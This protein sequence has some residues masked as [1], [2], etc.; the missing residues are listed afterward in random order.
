VT[1]RVVH[2][3]FCPLPLPRTATA[4]TEYGVELGRPCCTGTG[5]GDVSEVFSK[6]RIVLG[7]KVLGMLDTPRPNAGIGVLG[8][9]T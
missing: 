1:S 5:F 9:R 3:L 4:A 8:T 7:V 2:L 6:P